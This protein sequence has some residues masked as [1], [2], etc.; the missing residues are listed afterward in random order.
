VS[1]DE[2]C[3]NNVSEGFQWPDVVRVALLQQTRGRNATCRG[4]LLRVSSFVCWVRRSSSLMISV[5]AKG[6]MQRRGRKKL[7]LSARSTIYIRNQ[8]DA[9]HYHFHLSSN[10]QI[11]L[12]YFANC[13]LYIDLIM[14]ETPTANSYGPQIPPSTWPLDHIPGTIH[15]I[16]IE[17]LSEDAVESHTCD[18]GSKCIFIPN[19]VGPIFTP[20]SPEL[21][22][23]S[24]V[25]HAIRKVVL[26]K[27][28]LNTVVL[29]DA[30]HIASTLSSLRQSSL[31]YIM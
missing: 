13:R 1:Y 18:K 23:M 27:A 8:L 26:Q 3:R 24:L 14:D 10:I 15:D 6:G 30:D 29:Y 21:K 12:H 7:S 17:C 28:I 9:Q 20:L 25:D 11:T 22:S 19:P 31:R 2:V 4:R 5:P 16:N